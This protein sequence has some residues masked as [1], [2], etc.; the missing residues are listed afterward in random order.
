MAKYQ[1]KA[2]LNA[3]SEEGY[4]QT[5]DP[6]AYGDYQILLTAF[7]NGNMD[8]MKLVLNNY[9]YDDG[10]IEEYPADAYILVEFNDDG[11]ILLEKI[12]NTI[13]RAN[14]SIGMLV[15]EIVAL[16]TRDSHNCFKC[17][18]FDEERD[19]PSEINCDKC[20]NLTKERY[21]QMLLNQYIVK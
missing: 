17:T 16:K 6:K 12:D 15:D 20:N 11:F 18:L 1:I 7:D 13:S 9:R 4:N 21:R 3:P 5:N 10:A 2:M 14:E 8:V 19:C